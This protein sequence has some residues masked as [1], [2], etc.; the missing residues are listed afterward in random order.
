M[1]K[2]LHKIKNIITLCLIF[3]CLFSV[4]AYADGVSIVIDGKAKTFETLPIVEN[5]RVLLPI[6]DTFESIGAKVSWNDEAYEATAV[7]GD[8]K[9]TVKPNHD[10]LYINGEELKMDVLALERDERIFIPVRFAAGK[11]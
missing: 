10:T 3:V 9:V 7:K 5:E 8:K 11:E 1:Y 4:C 6:R 2:I